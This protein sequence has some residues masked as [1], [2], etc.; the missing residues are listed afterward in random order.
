VSLAAT[1]RTLDTHTIT[2]PMQVRFENEGE[3]EVLQIYDESDTTVLISC[4]RAALSTK[5]DYGAQRRV[6]CQDC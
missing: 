3:S 6:P 2:A 5:G 4:H 1:S